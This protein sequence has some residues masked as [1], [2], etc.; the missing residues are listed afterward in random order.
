MKKTF[1]P[2]TIGG[3]LRN[4]SQVND[5]FAIGADKIL[6][7]TAIRKDKKFVKDCIKKYGSQAVLCGIDF[8]LEKDNFYTYTENGKEKFSSLK[9]YF[10]SKKYENCELFLTSID[11]DGTGFGYE[12]KF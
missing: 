3:G 5:C 6:L 8:K 1:I 10:I 11:R 4:L 7:N 9:T 12:K 2:L